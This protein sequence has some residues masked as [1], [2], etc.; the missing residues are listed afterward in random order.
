MPK[1]VTAIQHAA[2]IARAITDGELVLAK[3]D[4]RSGV[5]GAVQ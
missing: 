3:I 4:L 1:P 2:H 5:K